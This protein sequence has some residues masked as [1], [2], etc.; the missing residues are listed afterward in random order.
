MDYKE[1]LAFFTDEMK[2]LPTKEDLLNALKEHIGDAGVN[3]I[4]DNID[5]IGWDAEKDRIQGLGSDF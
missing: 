4:W 1:K 3:K 2:I 5:T